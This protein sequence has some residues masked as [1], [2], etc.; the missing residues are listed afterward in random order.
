[1]SGILGVVVGFLFVSQPIAGAVALPFVMTLLL[2][3][4]A[5][6]S[7]IFNIIGDHDAQGDQRRDLDDHLGRHLILLG[8]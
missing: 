1:M 2:G 5:I 3:A 8:F 7:G 4:G 6:V